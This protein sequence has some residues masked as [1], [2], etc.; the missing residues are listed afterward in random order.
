MRPQCSA[1]VPIRSLHLQPPPVEGPN[2][3]EAIKK[4]IETKTFAIAEKPGDFEIWKSL[5]AFEKNTPAVIKIISR[6]IE[7]VKSE[8]EH[9]VEAGYL[10]AYAT[11]GKSTTYLIL[12]VNVPF[13]ENHKVA[14]HL[15]VNAMN[16]AVGSRFAS[17]VK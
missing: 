7:T 14:Q 17:G 5:S 2:P 1:K 13:M 15:M 4:F 12:S 10:L 16:H 9:W 3:S 11:R 6:G 8:I